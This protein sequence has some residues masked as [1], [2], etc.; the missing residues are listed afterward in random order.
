MIDLTR[1]Q[2]G[3]AGRGTNGELYFVGRLDTYLEEMKGIAGEVVS[4]EYELECG[5]QK[6]ERLRGS[7]E[8]VFE[9]WKNREKMGWCEYC[10]RPME[11]GALVRCQRCG[12]QVVGWCC[13]EHLRYD[14]RLHAKNCR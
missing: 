8:K 6:A 5:Q 1:I 13:E 7:A 11:L 12:S 9:A 3:D 14:Q 2:Y 4:K 10:G